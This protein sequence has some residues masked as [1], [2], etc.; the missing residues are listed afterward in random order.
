MIDCVRCG[1]PLDETD[2]QPCE[3]STSDRLGRTTD[4]EPT[5]TQR[6]RL[7]APER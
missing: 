5:P 7:S 1:H 6:A 2:P 4:P 3:E